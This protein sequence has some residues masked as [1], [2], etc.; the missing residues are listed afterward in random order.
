MIFVLE[1][2]GA[3][4]GIVVVVFTTFMLLAL[5]VTILP[6]ARYPDDDYPAD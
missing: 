3:C 6:A 4:V 1:A 2:I 5:A